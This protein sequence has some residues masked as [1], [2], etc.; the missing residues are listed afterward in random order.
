VGLSEAD[1]VDVLLAAP[2]TR[3]DRYTIL[4]HRDLDR[5]GLTAAVREFTQSLR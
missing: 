4:E 1:F 3:P 2:T 5:A